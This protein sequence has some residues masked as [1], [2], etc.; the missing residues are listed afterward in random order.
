M[1]LAYLA[2]PRLETEKETGRHRVARFEPIIQVWGFMKKSLGQKQN[3]RAR[4]D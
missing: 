1:R 2:C 4:W 3:V